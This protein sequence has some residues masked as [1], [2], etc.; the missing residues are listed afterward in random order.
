LPAR[1]VSGYASG[2][3]DAANAVYVVRELHAHSWAEVYF[4]EIGWV[5]FEPT[6]A[7]PEIELPPAGEEIVDG[8]K[9]ENASRLLNRFR[10]ET[11]VYWLSPVAVVL[12]WFL[13]YF[14][15]IERWLYARL[16]PAVAIE[17]IYRQLY[18]WGRPLA[19]ERAKAE[20]A[21]EFMTKLNDKIN[22]V[23]KQSHN[24]KYLSRTSQYIEYLT[25]RYQDSLFALHS[26]DKQDVTT[27]FHTWRHL[28]LRLLFVR[29]HVFLRKAL[30]PKRHSS[31]FMRE[32]PSL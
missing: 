12:L 22:I 3:Y 26:I 6:A 27:A 14:T 1:F 4:P 29:L 28:R 31:D 32:G 11:L 16:A 17:K 10:L 7:Q 19:G 15:W 2:S 25:E 24:P 21:Y 20:T 8:Q 13:L 18:R 9:D 23:T 5:E 30:F